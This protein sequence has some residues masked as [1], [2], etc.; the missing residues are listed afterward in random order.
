MSE[1]EKDDEE[2][3]LKIVV[4]EEAATSGIRNRARDH[5]SLSTPSGSLQL[6]QKDLQVFPITQNNLSLKETEIIS[7]LELSKMDPW[8]YCSCEFFTHLLRS[9]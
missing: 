5:F 7:W 6:K 8:D 2:I 4:E 9:L 3:M 1:T